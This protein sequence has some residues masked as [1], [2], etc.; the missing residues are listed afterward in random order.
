MDERLK[1]VAAGRRENG[2]PTGLESATRG[3]K[4]YSSGFLIL[5]EKPKVTSMRL[6]IG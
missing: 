5:N 1:F 3:V 2:D 4:R 6:A